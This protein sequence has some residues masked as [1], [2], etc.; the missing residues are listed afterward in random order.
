MEFHRLTPAFYAFYENCA[1]M[2]V[3]ND[4][5]YYVCVLELGGICYALPLRTHITHP[6]C[7]IAA[8]YDGQ[9]S[10][11]DFSKAVVITNREKFIDPDLVTIRQNE[12]DVLKKQE[13]L[14][15]KR[16]TSY[17]N[18]YKK[19]ILRRIKSPTLPIATVCRY[20]SLQY[21]HNILG[22]PPTSLP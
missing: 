10:G 5:P 2:L 22:L 12:F 3:K 11:L 17:V 9:K 6:F 16:F 15:N 19:E 13:H 18:L 7:F 1:E 4:R 8:E 20:S 21:F 14:I